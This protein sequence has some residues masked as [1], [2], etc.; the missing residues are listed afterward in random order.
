MVKLYSKTI[1]VV[2]MIKMIKLYQ[3]NIH[4]KRSNNKFIKQQLRNILLLRAHI[5]HLIYTK[6]RIDHVEPIDKNIK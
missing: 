1:M 6:I 2:H 3:K 5:G 4:F